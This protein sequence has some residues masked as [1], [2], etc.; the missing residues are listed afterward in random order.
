[1]KP[2]YENLLKELKK[3]NAVLVEVEHRM[4]CSYDRYR[5]VTPDFCEFDYIYF[6]D[7][8]SSGFSPSCFVLKHRTLEAEAM[9]SQMKRYDKREK[10]QI[11][12]M[13]VL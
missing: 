8:M 13:Q 1:M 12:K 7:F 6:E 5:I 9:V 10:L 4:W 2:T 11:T 3:G